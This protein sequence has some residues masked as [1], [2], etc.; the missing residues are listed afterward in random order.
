M[1]TP[2]HAT[3]PTHVCP[4]APEGGR[5]FTLPGTME[6]GG[7]FASDIMQ[8]AGQ[9]V[10][11]CVDMTEPFSEEVCGGCE[12]DRSVHVW[13]CA[14]CDCVGAH[15]CHMESLRYSMYVLDL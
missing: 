7:Y 6:G 8:F 9:L 15:V 11:G 3:T 12:R 13:M 14:H 5:K 4:F 10:S 2:T 1:T